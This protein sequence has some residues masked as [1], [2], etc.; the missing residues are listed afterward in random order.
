MTNIFAYNSLFIENFMSGTEPVGWEHI[1]H[2][3][4]SEYGTHCDKPT[5]AGSSEL[6]DDSFLGFFRGV[7]G[8]E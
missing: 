7:D 1:I 4:G 3:P 6:G 8:R 5:T 2:L